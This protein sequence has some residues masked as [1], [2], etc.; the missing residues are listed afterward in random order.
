[1]HL[2]LHEVGLRKVTSRIHLH[3]NIQ[4]CFHQRR[5]TTPFV[6]SNRRFVFR[7]KI[8]GKIAVWICITVDERLINIVDFV[9]LPGLG[10]CCDLLQKSKV[11]IRPHPF[12]INGSFIS[13]SRII[14]DT[15]WLVRIRS[16]LL[17]NGVILLV[18]S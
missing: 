6:I 4:P 3:S 10:L 7:V 2:K 14:L 17:Q 8:K 15:Q 1:M 9:A 11:E 16:Y 13:S 12:S 5:V 18:P